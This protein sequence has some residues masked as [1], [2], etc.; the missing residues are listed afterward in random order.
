VEGYGPSTYGDGFADVYDDWYAD[1]T[2]V[3]GTVAAVAALAPG[4]SVLELG[5]GTG[6]IALPLAGAGL[7]VTGVDASERML[8]RLRAKPGA[9][10]VTVWA[11]DVGREL[12][13]SR[14]DVVLATY[15]TFFNLNDEDAQRRCL[16]LVADRLAP[17]GRFVIEA[18][19]PAAAGTTEG[20]DQDVSVRRLTADRVV[21]SISRRDPARQRVDGQLVELR[22]GS[23]RLHPWSIRYLSPDQLDAMAAG[24]GLALEA[25]WGGW[26]R[27]P[28][29]A[30]DPSH[31][32]L[33]RR[34]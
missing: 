24:A 8:D 7:R 10:R 16:A 19:V 30:D 27:R 22:D 3:A 21:L 12:P 2:D 34:R 29:A 14:F 25:R 1:V 17:G 15:N 23:V 20:D 31:V 11:A 18:F 13:E 4:G 9:E 33:Y 32:S 5:V 28:L 26:H 6:R